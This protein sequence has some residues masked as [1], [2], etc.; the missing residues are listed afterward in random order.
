MRPHF[1]HRLAGMTRRAFTVAAGL[2]ALVIFCGILFWPERI[3]MHFDLGMQADSYGS[4][5]AGVALAAGLGIFMVMLFLGCAWLAGRIDLAL[6]NVRYPEFWK[7][8][9]NER[10]LRQRLAD[11]MYHVGAATLVLLAGV[12]GFVTEAAVAGRSELSSWSVALLVGYLLY[13]GGWTGWLLTRR[14]RPDR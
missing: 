3:P 9:D 11:D 1:K 10:R 5:W 14:Y 12:F 2:Y 13:T 4:K 6:V 8:P 7:A